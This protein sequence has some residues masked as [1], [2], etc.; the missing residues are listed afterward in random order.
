M[1]EPIKYRF[2]HEGKEYEIRVYTNAT[3]RA[4]FVYKD[5]KRIEQA[6]SFFNSHEE[7][8]KMAMDDRIEGTEASVDLLIRIFKEHFHRF[9]VDE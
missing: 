7:L 3:G 8:Q 1:A 5:G 4:L 9:K 2:E 6:Q